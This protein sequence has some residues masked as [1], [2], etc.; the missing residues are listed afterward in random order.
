MGESSA[1]SRVPRAPQVSRAAQFFAL[2]GTLLNLNFGISY[3]R[4]TY[5]VQ[6][7]QLWEPILI[8]LG[9]GSA[10]VTLMAGYSAMLNTMYSNVQALGQGN[11]ILTL[12]IVAGQVFVLILGLFWIISV[13]YFSRDASILT[14]LPLPA[15]TVVLARFGVVLANEYVT[16]ALVL[17]PAFYVYGT[18][19][20]AGLLYWIMCI[21]VFLLTPVIPL[22]LATAAAIVLMRVVNVRKSRTFFMFLGTAL[23]FGLYLWFLY[24]VMHQAPQ[25]EADIL[26]YLMTVQ[27]SLSRSVA[28]RFPP[29]LWA[30]FSLSKAGTTAGLSNFAILTVVSAGALLVA[31]G[32]GSRM[33]YAA[34]TAGG[35]EV[36]SSGTAGGR[37]ARAGRFRA[38]RSGAD[39]A[40]AGL[41]NAGRSRADE[42]ALPGSLWMQRSP[43]AAIA[44]KDMWVFLRTPTFVLNGLANV[45]VF[46][47]LLAVWFVAGGGPTGLGGPFAE[48]PGFA[49][50]LASPSFAAARALALAASILAV[51]GLNAVASS[52]FSRDGMQFWAHKVIPVPA[53]RQVRGKA[54]FTLAFQLVSMAPLVV[55][56]QLILR[57]DLAGLAMGT[58]IGIAASAWAA[59]ISLYVDMMRPYLTC[60]NPQRAMKSNLNAIISMFV[61]MVVSAGAGY[62]VVTALSAGLNHWLI[63]WSTFG[64]F[65]ALAGVSYRLLMTGAE[66]AFRRVEL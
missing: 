31:T 11:M 27:D 2:L 47:G 59:L 7:K 63:L 34:L 40:D 12:A 22:A 65:A 52:G 61:V 19:S 5:L 37:R 14:P 26:N 23:F 17:L 36:A 43:E 25:K 64:V 1:A 50:F 62:A 15:S 56:V 3:G 38:G 57:L 66:S 58:L 20:G 18:R 8:A 30:S 33:F 44:R 35:E 6:K 46:P 16:L 53:G 24:Y 42:R 21:P 41:S 49:E 45:L 60:D 4:Q 28:M 55:V 54:L 10:V 32:L 9:I 29:S 48:I 51:A 13:F 39:R